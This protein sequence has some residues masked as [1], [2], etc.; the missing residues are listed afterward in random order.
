MWKIQMCFCLIKW[1]K[2]GLLEWWMWERPI[3]L[4]YVIHY[5]CHKKDIKTWQTVQFNLLSRSLTMRPQIHAQLVSRYL[6]YKIQ[7]LPTI[8]NLLK[9]ITFWYYVTVLCTNLWTC[10]FMNFSFQLYVGVSHTFVY[11]CIIN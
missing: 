10:S 3:Q 2:P 11:L 8:L 7:S 1:A 4:Y 5:K 9:H 6:I